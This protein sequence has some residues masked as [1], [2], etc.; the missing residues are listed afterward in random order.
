MDPPSPKPFDVFEEAAT[1]VCDADDP[2]D[3]NNKKPKGGTVWVQVLLGS[4]KIGQPSEFATPRNVDALKKLVKQEYVELESISAPCCQ[5]YHS[6][7]T[8]GGCAVPLAANSEL[9][10]MAIYDDPI[11]IV[12]PAEQPP[13]KAAKS[14]SMQQLVPAAVPTAA[15]GKR[16]GKANTLSIEEYKAAMA[17]SANA[18][19]GAGASI[20]AYV[21]ATPQRL[22][23]KQR[24]ASTCGEEH[25]TM[26]LRVGKR[27][28]CVIC[29]RK[30]GY[31]CSHE[32][33]QTRIK[34]A[35][36]I[37]Q[38][39]GVPLCSSGSAPRVDTSKYGAYNDKTCLELHAE[40]Y[41][42]EHFTATAVVVQEDVKE[43]V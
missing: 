35:A 10:L 15:T 22:R 20:A 6:S 33:C 13:P 30:T 8:A 12:A 37:G 25:D 43:E 24:Q 21:P 32:D 40:R 39:F 3:D 18:A 27:R 11:K 9:P 23:K 41:N 16:K 26:A 4:R 31:E 14:A 19:P 7:V 36:N 2:N 34:I 17:A 28:R 38:L 1:A 5:V 29:M 42:E